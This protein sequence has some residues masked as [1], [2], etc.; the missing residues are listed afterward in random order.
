MLNFKDKPWFHS[1]EQEV[2]GRIVVY[3]KYMDKEVL[4]G[5]PD[6]LD[7]K[8]VVVHFVG[9][10]LATR[11]M[12]TDNPSMRHSFVSSEPITTPVLVPDEVDAMTSVDEDKSLSYLISELE[13]LERQCGSNT[14]ADIFFE[15]KDQGNAVTEWSKRYPDVRKDL[16]TLYD[17]YG[18]DVLYEELEM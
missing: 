3:V 10:K 5:V 6:T 12:F 11:E 4:T 17:S 14:L 16:E 1:M 9:A 18:F 8:Q 2:S 15:I 13:R 7:G